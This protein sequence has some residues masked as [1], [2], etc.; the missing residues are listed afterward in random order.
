MDQPKRQ[1]PEEQGSPPKRPRGISGKEARPLAGI[2]P[3]EDAA[4]MLRII[5]EGCG[6]VDPEGWDLTLD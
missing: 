3:D 5:E 4:E 2:L 6:Q 1:H